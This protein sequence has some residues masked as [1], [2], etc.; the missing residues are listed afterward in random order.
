VALYP[1]CGQGLVRERKRR[2]RLRFADGG[3]LA[4]D[5]AANP[6]PAGERQP[7]LVPCRGGAVRGVLRDVGGK[8]VFVR[9]ADGPGRLEIPGLRPGLYVLRIRGT[10]YSRNHRV[11]VY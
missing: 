8:R 9:E 10:G 5:A 7:G 11:M 3:G 2:A 4:E 1:L 6:V